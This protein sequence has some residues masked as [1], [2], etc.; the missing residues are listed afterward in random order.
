MQRQQSIQFRPVKCDKC[1]Q[2][3]YLKICG[4]NN[5]T[6]FTCSTCRMGGN[7]RNYGRVIGGRAFSSTAR[8]M[9]HRS[10]HDKKK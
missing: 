1:G 7:H 3:E 9:S 2:I 6:A 5:L 4:N 8:E 10:S